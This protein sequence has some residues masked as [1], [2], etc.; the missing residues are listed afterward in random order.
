MHQ[1]NK[2]RDY[3]HFKLTLVAPVLCQ[4]FNQKLLKN[5]QF[6]MR[7]V[8]SL[9]NKIDRS[10]LYLHKNCCDNHIIKLL[11]FLKTN[12]GACVSII[13]PRKVMTCMRAI[14]ELLWMLHR[15]FVAMKPAEVQRATNIINEHYDFSWIYN[16]QKC[17]L[18]VQSKY[19]A[20][21]RCGQ[22]K[23]KK[24]RSRL[25]SKHNW[26]TNDK[27]YNNYL[28]VLDKLPADIRLFSDE[29]GLMIDLDPELYNETSSTTD[30]NAR[31]ERVFADYY[32]FRES[33]AWEVISETDTM[34]DSLCDLIFYIQAFV[35]VHWLRYKGGQK[36]A[37]F[38]KPG[39]IIPLLLLDP[40]YGRSNAK[41]IINVGRE[42]LREYSY[43][44]LN[45]ESVKL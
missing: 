18:N 34:D 31:L 43:K 13:M 19:G 41:K 37:E 17:G 25:C 14:N 15:R 42:K 22:L 12:K 11:D 2:K 27:N 1:H 10:L 4:L 38:M 23:E 20:W 24:Y 35:F 9:S 28:Y 40:K 33:K 16:A 44:G 21:K 32:S 39:I 7:F 26:N 30:E 3:D 5:E 6:F 45:F 29:I 8:Y 36:F